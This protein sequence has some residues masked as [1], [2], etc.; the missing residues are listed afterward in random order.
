M[1]EYQQ[2]SLV[3]SLVETL[4]AHGS[5][6]GETHLHKTLYFLEDLLGVP[7]G[8][9]FVLYKHGPYSFELLDTIG[10]L[11]ASDFLKWQ[12]QPHPYGAS[13]VIGPAG[14]HLKRMYPKMPK[15]YAPQIEFVA[16]HLALK[17][18]RDLEKLA[19]ALW[20][21]QR[22]GGGPVE[23][24]AVRIHQLKPHISVPDAMDAVKAVDELNR[25][26]RESGIVMNG[27]M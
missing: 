4:K 19:T 3:L 27:N 16:A 22:E 1:N 6:T 20:V 21:T 8:L 5:W 18:V 23:A 17:S 24:R 15:L 14:E 13:A 25:E 11:E 2:A 26:A 9:K 10:L 7:A 12:P